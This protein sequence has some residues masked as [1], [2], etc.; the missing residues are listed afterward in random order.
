MTLFWTLLPLYLLGNFHCLGMCGPIA[1]LLG[2]NPRK[3]FYLLGRAVS[4]T[5]AGVI[6]A[7]F[8]A[9]L[10]ILLY[11]S[12]LD[13]SA[14]FLFSLFFTLIGISYLAPT[15]L[16]L[17]KFLNRFFLWTQKKAAPL[18]LEESP[19]K[20]F[21]FG[22]FTVLL[23]CGQSLFVFSSIALE[24]DIISGAFNGWAF[25]LLTT[26]SLF[27]AMHAGKKFF[28][29]GSQISFVLGLLSLLVALSL[30]LRGLA[31]LGWISSLSL[32]FFGINLPLW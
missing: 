16:P 27:F 3:H 12:G 7:F 24:Q 11:Y 6:S 8:G 2:K 32:T 10:S 1:A 28:F 31:Q 23:P 9:S 25:S 4:F 30:F 19:L 26:P 5:V 17:P 14:L 18:L 15:K 22:F 29:K 20:T 21:L 13:K